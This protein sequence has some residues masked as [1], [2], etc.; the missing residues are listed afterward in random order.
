MSR[1]W[2]EQ[3][4]LARDER[5]LGR[6]SELQRD[7]RHGVLVPVARG[8]YRRSAAISVDDDR[9]DD[10]RFLAL[11]RAT[12]LLARGEIVFSGLSAAAVWGLP[13]IGSWPERVSALVAPSLGG[14]SNTAVQRTYVGHDLPAV[15]CDGLRVTS[16]AQTV[17]D[18]G[19]T[20]RFE[21]AVTI[22]D[23]AL[24]RKGVS[25]DRLWATLLHN[26]RAPGVAKCRSVIEFASGD[27]ASAGESLSRVAIRRLGIEAPE[28]QVPFHDERGLI[29]IV[30][31]WWPR[32]RVIGEFDGRGKYLRDEFTDGRTTAE[33]VLD[34]KA[35][36]DR[37]RPQVSAVVRWGWAEAQRPSL[38]GAKLHMLR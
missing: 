2:S 22:A 15:W 13:I 34:E 23:A 18:V 32:L 9:E 10:D 35:R 19:R 21:V 16:L 8:A 7:V 6:Q 29:G 28:L 36:E 4:V 25:K 27:A 20:A 5:E 11:L 30:D 12:H 17:I 24:Q 37:L 33:V 38:L 1:D 3:F 31:F 14:R 26:R